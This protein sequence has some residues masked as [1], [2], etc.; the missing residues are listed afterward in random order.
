MFSCFMICEHFE[1]SFYNFLKDMVGEEILRK[2]H[3]YK[4]LFLYDSTGIQCKET[5]A[6][7]KLSMHLWRWYCKDKTV[8]IKAITQRTR[9]TRE[10]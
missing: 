3:A 2:E 4:K 8:M 6:K 10:F 1:G 7:L 5:I 9:Y